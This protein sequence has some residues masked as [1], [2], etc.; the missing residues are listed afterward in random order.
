MGFVEHLKLPHYVDFQ[1]ELALVR[2]L[3][4]EWLAQREQQQE[5]ADGRAPDTSREAAE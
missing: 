2:Q 4:A 1:A 3:R 5:A